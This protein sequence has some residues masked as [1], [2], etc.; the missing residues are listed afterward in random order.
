MPP[1]GSKNTLY[2]ARVESA[3]HPQTP[4]LEQIRM[5]L[6]K[7]GFQEWLT[8][9]FGQKYSSLNTYNLKEQ[10]EKA[11]EILRRLKESYPEWFPTQTDAVLELIFVRHGESCANALLKAKGLRG[12]IEHKLYRDPE[13]TTKGRLASEMK[14]N[15]LGS[16]LE[17]SP[18]FS[19]GNFTIGSSPLIRAQETAYWMLSKPTGKAIDVMPFMGEFGGAPGVDNTPDS[20]AV[21][22]KTLKETFGLT[23]FQRGKDKR[24]KPDFSKFWSWALTEGIRDGWFTKGTDNVYR[25]VIFTHSNLLKDEFPVNQCVNPPAKKL[26]G[27]RLSNND[28]LVTI[29][30]PGNQS[31]EGKTFLDS[32][33]VYPKWH[34]YDTRDVD[35]TNPPCGIDE[36]C[37]KQK[38]VPVTQTCTKQG[39]G[40]RN[41]KTRRRLSR[42]RCLSRRLQK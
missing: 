5:L 10:Q 40:N 3:K 20:V 18:E 24:T 37:I 1:N 17:E 13:L 23:E 34:Y 35:T 29:Y 8:E 31:L 28:F 42:R 30:N 11:E 9:T 27:G 38:N 25:A 36:R 16:I 14:Q 21:Q 19:S 15:R 4:S 22:D 26:E 6:K 41:R 7:P 32:S 2:S 33:A 12:L 39:G